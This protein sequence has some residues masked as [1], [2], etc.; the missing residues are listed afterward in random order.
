[1]K[2]TSEQ[3]WLTTA[4]I[5]ADV[6]DALTLCF[7]LRKVMTSGKLAVL[8]S[9]K[10][11]KVMREALHYGFD[12]VFLLEEDRNTAGLENE[13]FAKLFALTLKSF[14]KIL[15]VFPNMLAV[16]NCDELFDKGKNEK[17]SLTFVTNENNGD[18]SSILLVSPSLSIF[19]R[20]MEALAERNGCE[21]ETF[22]KKWQEDKAQTSI[23]KFLHGPHDSQ[24][25]F[26]LEQEKNISIVNLKAV[27]ELTEDKHGFLGKPS[28]PPPN[29]LESQVTNDAIA[30]V[31]S[32]F[33]HFIS[34]TGVESEDAKPFQ[35]SYFLFEFIP[36]K[37]PR[38]LYGSLHTLDR[39]MEWSMK[40]ELIADV[41]ENRL[42]HIKKKVKLIT[43]YLEDYQGSTKKA[44]GGLLDPTHDTPEGR[45]KVVG[46]S[47][48]L[49]H[50]MI[51]RYTNTISKL[52]ELLSSAIYR[53][54]QQILGDVLDLKIYGVV[55]EIH[56]ME[57]WEVH[58][59]SNNDKSSF[60]NEILKEYNESEV[61]KLPLW[62]KHM[63]K[64]MSDLSFI[65][66]HEV[67][68]FNP[69]VMRIGLNFDTKNGGSLNAKQCAEIGVLAL[70]R[71]YYYMA[72]EWLEL[73]KSL[74]LSKNQSDNSIPVD[75]VS[76]LLDIAIR[77][78]NK[79]FW[80]ES[81][82]NGLDVYIQPT[83]EGEPK[84]NRT[85]TRKNVFFNQESEKDRMLWASARYWGLCS[86]AKYQTP[87]EQ[88]NLKCYF[89]SKSH[90]YL[91][92]S[93]VKTEVLSENPLILQ[94]Y[95][96]LSNDSI[97][98]I[99]STAV[100]RLELSQVVGDLSMEEATKFRT[101]AGSFLLYQELPRLYEHSEIISGLRLKNASERGQVVEY[102]H[103]RFYTFHTDAV[104]SKL[105]S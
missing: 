29:D 83:F 18:S 79:A 9:P 68:G 85:R 58:G 17:C 84:M 24:N 3:I 38:F 2:K 65:H 69:E 13:D 105:N 57:M 10:V 82:L 54:N 98:K 75:L 104:R 20:L 51:D 22:L 6:P 5:E 78:H 77:E 73:S 92:I 71:H 94:F 93:P 81:L 31:G 26:F 90:P 25:G 91:Y 86:G 64:Y 28:L 46:S 74:L 27:R 101:S 80:S 42:G 89:N 62:P 21:L 53:E 72:I 8:V 12:F 48:V 52:Q 61:E 67:Y 59:S 45:G 88:T 103:G 55:K 50:R 99:K 63:D 7:S 100:P 56:E 47:A 60:N 19:N 70:A 40:E 11:S 37:A 96:V 4:L 30:I 95:D 102:T 15:V 39:L 23:I 32:T 44:I 49:A 43:S 34:G 35:N 87:E 97:E 76:I 1:M 33:I 16:R 14:D 36:D 66:I 41:L